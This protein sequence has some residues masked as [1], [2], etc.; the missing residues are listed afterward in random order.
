MGEAS[1]TGLVAGGLSELG[2]A[3]AAA[4]G[5]GLAAQALAQGGAGAATYLVNSTIHEAFHRGEAPASFSG[6]SLLTGTAGAAATPVL[7]GFF[8]RL[9][10]QAL[11]PQ[12]GWVW[13]PNARAWDA[14]YQELVM[15]LGQ[16]VIQDSFGSPWR[17]S[18]KPEQGSQP[19]PPAVLE[20]PVDEKADLTAQAARSVL[21]SDSQFLAAGEEYVATPQYTHAGQFYSSDG[22]IVSWSDARGTVLWRDADGVLHTLHTNQM[23]PPRSKLRGITRKGIVCETPRF[24]TLFP[25]QGNLGASSEESPD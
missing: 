11:N 12:T 17:H 4:H 23:K 15:G 9:A 8:S 19:I 25:L 5:D 24:L 2:S 14:F 18:P 7:G 10:Q 20:D 16:V 22:D 13:H 1:L 21:Q 3:A 6:W